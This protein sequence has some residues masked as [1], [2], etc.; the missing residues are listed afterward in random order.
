VGIRASEVALSGT[1]VPCWYAIHTRHQHETVVQKQLEHDRI[2]TYL[3]LVSEVRQW[4]DRKKRITVPLFSCFVFIR[5][6]Y[7]AQMHQSV[8]QKPGVVGFV[9][10]GRRGTPIPDCEIE[11]IRQLLASSIP[12][13]PYPFVN[14]G[15]RVRIRGGAL[16][17]MEGIVVTN[18]GRRFIVSVDTIQRSVAVQLEDS[19]YG[20]EV[21]PVCKRKALSDI[22]RDDRL[23]QAV[24]M[25]Q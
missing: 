11:G 25:S 18:T 13:S 12:L 5:A 16:D 1:E 9:G 4:S 3:P 17:S 6:I 21:I 22:L 20:I 15:Q 10:V 23:G 24:G 14:T 19:S 8:I 7:S 2:H